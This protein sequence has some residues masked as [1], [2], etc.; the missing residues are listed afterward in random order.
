MHDTILTMVDNNPFSNLSTIR[1]S[2]EGQK[3]HTDC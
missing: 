3:R 2:L 1:I